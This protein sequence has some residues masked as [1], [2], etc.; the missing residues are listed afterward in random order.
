M[1]GLSKLNKLRA[2]H[3]VE[4]SEGFT[5]RLDD[6]LTQYTNVDDITLKRAPVDTL[7]GVANQLLIAAER[8]EQ[9]EN[10][11]Q[12]KAYERSY[13]ERADYSITSLYSDYKDLIEAGEKDWAD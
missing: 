9:A 1:K 4:Y 6:D 7:E 10:M 12:A 13:V 5:Y 8:A 11:A 2:R 3:H